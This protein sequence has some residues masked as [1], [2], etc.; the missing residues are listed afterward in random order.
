MLTEKQE[1]KLKKKESK[2]ERNENDPLLIIVITVLAGA[3]FL[4]SNFK[5]VDQIQ[6]CSLLGKLLRQLGQVPRR[7]STGLSTKHTAGKHV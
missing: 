5:F 7:K 4:T 6:P 3:Q 2:K 1:G